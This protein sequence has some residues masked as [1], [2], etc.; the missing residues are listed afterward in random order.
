MEINF[1]GTK[2]RTFF[3]LVTYKKNLTYFWTNYLS[4]AQKNYLQVRKTKF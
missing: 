1:G 2:L 3:K 4:Q